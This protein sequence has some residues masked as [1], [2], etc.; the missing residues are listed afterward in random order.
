MFF[1]QHIHVS[2]PSHV[3]PADLPWPAGCADWLDLPLWDATMP[4]DE[5]CIYH[6]GAYH[7]DTGA[8]GFGVTSFLRSGTTWYFGGFVAGPL[9]SADSY[10]AELYG[11]FVATKLAHDILK[12]IMLHQSWAPRVWMGFDSM[13]VGQQ[14]AG[15]WTCYRH[16]GLGTV[17]R[18]LR[19]LMEVRFHIEIEDYHIPAHRGEPGNEMA[20]TLATAGAQAIIA[21]PLGGLLTQPLQATFY[22][23][24]PWFW[25]LF[26]Q[27]FAGL[28][29]GHDL[30]FPRKPSTTPSLT[31]LPQLEAPAG[32]PHGLLD[33]V[34]CSCNVL[35]LKANQVETGQLG[36][37]RLSSILAQLDQLRCA[38]FGFQETRSRQSMA[39]LRDDYILISGEATAQGHGGVLIGLSRRHPHGYLQ[40][41]GDPTPVYFSEDS[42]SVIASSSRFLVLRI[43]TAVLK[44][45][46][47]SAHAPHSGATLDDIQAWWTSLHQLITPR[48]STWPMLLMCDANAR[49]GAHTS[50]QIGDHQA[51]PYN[52]K[53]L[54]FM[55]FLAQMS[56]FLPSTFVDFHLGPSGTWK[57]PT[58]GW[59]RNDFIGLPLAWEYTTLESW[60]AIEVDTSLHHEDHRAVCAHVCCA[61]NGAPLPRLMRQPKLVF[62]E[63]KDVDWNSV[64]AALPPW[65]LDVHTHYDYVQRTLAQQAIR[66]RRHRCPLKQTMTME[67]WSLVQ[68][69]RECRVALHEAT[70]LQR[71]TLLQ[72]AFYGWAGLCTSDDPVSL[73][74]AEDWSSVVCAQDRLIAQLLF[75]FRRLGRMVTAAMRTDDRAFFAHL[76]ARASEFLHPSDVRQFWQVIRS[77]LPKFKQRRIHHH[78]LKL[79]ILEDQW[80][81]YFEQLEMGS[82]IAPQDL[83]ALCSSFQTEHGSQFSSFEPDDL[84]T[85]FDLERE[86]RATRAH[87]ATGF[88]ALPSQFYHAAPVEL[89]R[90]WYPL[91]LKQYLWQTEPLQSKGGQMTLIPKAGGN[92]A[93][94]YRGIMLLENLGKRMHALVRKTLVDRLLPLKP[95]GQ[96]GGFP[97]Q[98][99]PFGAQCLQTFGRLT[100]RA[101]FSSAVVFVD[102][103]NA[104]HRLVRELVSGAAYPPDV[105]HVLSHLAE[106]SARGVQAWL[107]FP[108]L[109]ARLGVPEKLTVLLQDIQMCTWMTVADSGRFCRT[110]RGSRPGSPLS[111][112]HLPCL[113]ARCD[114]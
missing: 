80:M 100:A 71:R 36:A 97:K 39:C 91:L 64:Y 60:V 79:E 69:K 107:N 93:A 30:F 104:F 46:V 83:V 3:P 10:V 13:S 108:S 96:L 1:L 74:P 5:L 52:E 84:P 73:Q 53:A 102:L 26:D 40:T 20:D 37:S 58:A 42:Y 54:P 33:F 18:S 105:D 7:S 4:C 78:P 72:A 17:I 99:A 66:Q 14:A 88:D 48:Y 34:V 70:D 106:G 101:N 75:E 113:D 67:T 24:M 27:Q 43:Q 85:L 87:R 16:P 31:I 89:A 44:A 63:L 76:S 77:T 56:T 2:C 59:R 45:I 103:A 110:R 109:L 95:A 81:P 86:M 68:T 51:E 90:T 112:Y 29:R 8:A 61:G 15:Q 50:A 41:G 12:I 32:Q 55:D 94:G 114:L 9:W 49:V 57:H 62:D 98:Q 28:W 92:K 6:D 35:T 11:S 22:Q 47:I 21:T 65:E 23:A 38:V 19:H 25:M 82:E 111:R